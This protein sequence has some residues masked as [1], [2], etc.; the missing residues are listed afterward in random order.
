M[1]LVLLACLSLVVAHAVI[2]SVSLYALAFIVSL[3]SL[4]VKARQI[5][6]LLD[7]GKAY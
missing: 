2:V 3:A 5:R 4:G 7:D 1:V 6:L